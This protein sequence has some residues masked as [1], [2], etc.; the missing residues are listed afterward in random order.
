MKAN[1]KIYLL[2]V[3]TILFPIFCNGQ[4]I[5]SQLQ[6]IKQQQKYEQELKKRQQEYEQEQKENE[7]KDK[8][9][10]IKAQLNYEGLIEL[11]KNNDLDYIDK[12][13]KNIG[14]LFE[15]TEKEISVK[16]DNTIDTSEV[17]TWRLDK[18]IYSSITFAL[19][20]YSYSKNYSNIIYRIA[21]EDAFNSFENSII[22]NGFSKIQNTETIESALQS[23]YQNS[24]YEIILTKH[25]KSNVQ[26]GSEILYN[27]TIFNFKNIENLLKEKKEAE[28]KKKELE[29][30]KIREKKLA[31]QRAKEE[32]KRLLEEKRIKEE[33]YMNFIAQG[34]KAFDKR[35]YIIAKENYEKALEIYPEKK[36]EVSLK[37]QNVKNI[38][39]FLI[40]RKEKI[41]NLNEINQ[42]E[43]KKNETYIFSK[44]KLLLENSKN[45]DF[46]NINIVYQFDSLGKLSFK[47]PSAV[48]DQNFRKQLETIVFSQPMI[49]GY[50]VMAKATFNFKFE[51]YHTKIKV[52]NKPKGKFSNH[53]D[54]F[55]YR[56]FFN[57]EISNGAPYG[58]YHFDLNKI[59]INGEIFEENRLVKIKSYGP[60][61]VFLSMIVPGLGRHFVNLGDKNSENVMLNIAGSALYTGGLGLLIYPFADMTGISTGIFTYGFAGLSLYYFI[62][63][64]DIVL[65]DYTL[66]HNDLAIGF[67]FIAG[68]YYIHELIYV[69][70]KGSSNVKK[71]NAWE[72]NHIGLFYEQNTNGL[73]LS[74]SLK[75]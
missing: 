35:N 63:K 48:K 68:M 26:E 8:N 13:L 16:D 59:T 7:L 51:K 39:D 64:K 14:W 25:K 28:Q 9:R 37:I 65:T 72:N 6:E 1:K 46:Q 30:Q 49:Y 24:E 41:Y 45:V 36:D 47:I 10:L 69:L 40:D 32:E 52:I 57:S 58:K 74:Y 55:K 17:V 56:S 27:I 11:L 71:A 54:F 43:Y 73:G 75:F 21:S 4:S 61:Y 38:E 20:T 44:L 12:Y 22:T 42:N 29:E 50:P 15:K 31:E 70:A 34:D 5:K 53:D 23:R 18:N 66:T 62:S 33:N 60:E 2:L 19:L 67:G 3:Y